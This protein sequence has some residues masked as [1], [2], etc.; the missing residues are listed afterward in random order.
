MCPRARVRGVMCLCVCTYVLVCAC[1]RVRVH[2]WAVRACACV[3]QSICVT[4]QPPRA[5]HKAK[6]VL[7]IP[8]YPP[9]PPPASPF[10]PSCAS[11]L[12]GQRHVD[13]V[14]R[15]QARRQRKRRLH[16]LPTREAAAPRARKSERL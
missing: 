12:S 13:V 4:Q 15:R 16:A 7:H 10:P 3:C 1:V 8:V 6:I 5:G 2:E 14:R 11:R 9:P